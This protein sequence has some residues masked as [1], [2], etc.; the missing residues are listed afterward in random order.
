DHCPECGSDVIRDEAEATIRCSGGLFCPAQRRQAI[1]HFAAR[2]AMDVEGLGDKL[3]DQLVAVGLVETPADLYKLTL[4]AVEGL[5]RMG[6][7]SAENLLQALEKS[8]QTTFG[9]FLFA[10]GIREVGEATANALA[11]HYG[12]LDQ[13]MQADTE[14][15]QQVSDVGPIVAEHLVTFFKQPHNQEVIQALLD[16]G[17]E[18]EPVEMPDVD[19]LT[20]AGK[21]FVITGTLSLPRDEIKQKLLNL[22]AKVTGSVSKKTDYLIAGEDAGSK[23]AKAEALG[24]VILDEDQLN[25]LLAG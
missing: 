19:S 6:R 11:K 12:T 14:A 20:L 1:K 16:A 13:L 24:V 10:L 15:L 3:V 7:K 17:V 9:R 5:E 4:P 25:A 23:R 2:R 18:W 22:G 8:K 21:T